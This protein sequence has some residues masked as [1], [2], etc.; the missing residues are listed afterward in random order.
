[1]P[2]AVF[3]SLLIA[4]ILY[5][6]LAKA[7]IWQAF[8]NQRNTL[9][10]GHAA[11]LGGA[12]TAVA[13]D[14]TASYYNPAGLG[15]LKN[16]RVELAGQAYR[17]AVTTYEDV[18]GDLPF[19]ERSSTIYP[20]Y[21]GGALRGQNLAFGYA[22]L[23]LDARNN[24]QRD[25][26]Q[27][28]AGTSEDLGLDY[29]RSYQETSSYNWLGGA[30]ALKF[31]NS[32]SLGAGVF[33]YQ[34]DI[35]YTALELVTTSQGHVLTDAVTLAS[36]NTG[37]AHVVGI[38]GHLGDFSIGLTVRSAVAL[39]NRTTIAV[40]QVQYAANE[41]GEG[42]TATVARQ[43]E[44]SEVYSDLNPRTW[45]LG[46][47]YRPWSFLLVAVDALYHQGVSSPKDARYDLHNTVNGSAGIELDFSVLALH[48]G[49]FSNRSMYARP[50]RDAEEQPTAIDYIG[51]AYGISFNIKGIVGQ[52]GLVHQ[53]GVGQG[54]VRSGSLAVQDARA[55]TRT[56]IISGNA[57]LY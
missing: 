9:P 4:L 40:D 11:L 43:E 51:T 26:I 6:A 27:E 46:L 30:F 17:T 13:D 12:F 55:E 53:S 19:S 37:V 2:A 31:S 20:S 16:P 47:A 3:H 18:I 38:M 57:S 25:N 24:Y 45:T 21:F 32:W 14:A 1:M 44:K 15:F 29:T 35:R 33:Y 42:G 10:G 49:Y 28:G 8:G 23:N 22:F 41:D 50:S 36:L 56:Y 52:L 48:G 54:Q 5:P 39:S 34:R 7:D